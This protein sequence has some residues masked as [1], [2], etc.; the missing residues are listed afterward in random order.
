MKFNKSINR[1]AKHIDF[2]MLVYALI[3]KL[4]AK[5]LVNSMDIITT[6]SIIFKKAYIKVLN[7]TLWLWQ[8]IYLGFDSMR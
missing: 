6:M 3:M 5:D 2:T 1:L 7:L 4:V 8:E